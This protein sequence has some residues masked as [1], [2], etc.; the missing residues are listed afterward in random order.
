[1]FD[2]TQILRPATAADQL[3]WYVPLRESVPAFD[4]YGRSRED[5]TTVFYV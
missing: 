5:V 1:M 4:V 2:G 3:G